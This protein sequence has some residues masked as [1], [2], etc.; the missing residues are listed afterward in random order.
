MNT[1]NQALLKHLKTHKN[2][3]TTWTAF[4][5]LGIS[6][7]WKRIGELEA[8]GYDIERERI[9]AKNRYGNLCRIT[10]YKMK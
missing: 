9:V 4:E 10:R 8:Q 2:G 6:C 1:Q 7:L 5:N 3:I